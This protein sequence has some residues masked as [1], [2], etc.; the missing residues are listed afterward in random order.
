MC[1]PS[2][3]EE[4]G[5]GYIRHVLESIYITYNM[6]LNPFAQLAGEWRRDRMRNSYGILLTITLLL[7]IIGCALSNEVREPMT[8]DKH[9]YEKRKTINVFGMCDTDNILACEYIG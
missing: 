4:Q 9:P 1:T 6:S 3:R 2:S 8:H 7:L 5:E